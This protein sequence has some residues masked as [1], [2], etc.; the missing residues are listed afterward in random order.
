MHV[1]SKKQKTSY[2]A[3]RIIVLKLLYTRKIKMNIVQ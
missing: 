1:V 2:I 3:V